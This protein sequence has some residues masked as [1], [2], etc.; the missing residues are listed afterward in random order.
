LYL[1]YTKTLNQ[2]Q[3]VAGVMKD[4]LWSKI[5]AQLQD[6]ITK[7]EA[8]EKFVLSDEEKMSKIT[9]LLE[10]YIAS[11]TETEQQAIEKQL[12]DA[13]QA[14]AKELA[15]EM[16]KTVITKIALNGKNLT[17]KA[18]G[19]VTGSVLNQFAMDEAGDNFRIA[20]TKNQTWLPYGDEAGQK[21][22]NNLYVLDK[23]MKTVG[24]LEELA[25]GERIYSVR[26][27]GKRA[28][29]VT[30]QQTDPL[31]VIDLSEATK[32]KVLGELKMPG[33]SNYLHP[34]DDTTLIGIGKETIDK[35]GQ[36]LTSG[37]KLSLFD[38]ANVKAPKEIAKYE[39]GGRGSDSIALYDH[40]AFLFS[41]DK[42]LLAIPVS[43]TKKTDDNSWGKFEFSG[44]AVFDI[45]KQGFKLK[46]KIDHS[47]GGKSGIGESWLNMPYY[48]NSVKRALYIENNLYSVSSRY[49]KIN[50]LKDLSE[51]KSI[52][53]KDSKDFEVITY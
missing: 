38:V 3:I 52:K 42:N 11:L 22:F 18:T 28:Y 51:V 37:L 2:T 34:Y 17:Y 6:K 25:T 27:M 31:F 50:A 30:F 23:D 21:S 10:T 7:I 45:N 9:M 36:I 32:P 46:G 13:T 24:S 48:D 41:K 16:E 44:L 19:E 8:A 39:M 53:L 20:T 47:D 14:K 5:D 49:V 35:N 15:K 29:M 12:K 4:V 43:L 40:K 33:F 26:F 1:T